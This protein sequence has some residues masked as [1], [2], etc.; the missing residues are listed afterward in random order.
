VIINKTLTILIRIGIGLAQKNTFLR[1]SRE[2]TCVLDCAAGK[3][4]CE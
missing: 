3:P 1:V 4:L 2:N